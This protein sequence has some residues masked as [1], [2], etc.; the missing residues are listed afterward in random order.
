MGIAKLIESM[1]ERK[2]RKNEVDNEKTCTE[3]ENCI[4]RSGTLQSMRVRLFT[5]SRKF[6]GQS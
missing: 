5:P 6:R 4:W 2:T 1:D 3:V